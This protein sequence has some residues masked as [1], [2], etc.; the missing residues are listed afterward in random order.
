MSDAAPD[1][2]NCYVCG[3]VEQCETCARLEEIATRPTFDRSQD[4]AFLALLRTFIASGSL[5]K[6][7]ASRKEIVP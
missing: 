7:S 3:L 1:M 6:D 5:P 4:A 2:E